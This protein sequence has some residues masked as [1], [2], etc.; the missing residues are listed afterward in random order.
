[1]Y[2]LR[3]PTWLPL[4][5]CISPLCWSEFLCSHP[6]YPSNGICLQI[7]VRVRSHHLS[8]SWTVLTLFPRHILSNVGRVA[9]RDSSRTSATVQ[10]LFVALCEDDSIYGLF[11]SMKGL[12][13]LYFARLGSIGSNSLTSYQVYEQIELLSKSP[14]P[15]RSK[16]FSRSD[17]VSSSRTSSP[18]QDPSSPGKES[19][20]TSSA[21]SRISSDASPMSTIAP[22]STSGSRSSFDKGR[23][24]KMF[25][26][27]SNDRDWEGQ[28]GHKRSE[29]VLSEDTK[30]TLTAYNE[31]EKPDLEVSVLPNL[32]S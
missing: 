12:K 25:S 1:V 27:T 17:K 21:R 20:A 9:S 19:S 23:A 16:S 32:V 18:L 30:Q 22:T 8:F 26:R 29:S 31:S 2:H 3:K 7:H 4:R 6:K 13:I 5:R 24:M 10:D 28:G 14:K 11:K 15:K